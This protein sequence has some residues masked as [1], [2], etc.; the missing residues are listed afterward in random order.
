MTL[1][2]DVFTLAYALRQLGAP[3]AIEGAEAVRLE[4]VC[5]DSRQAREGSLFVALP[6]ERTD[7]HLYVA[8]AFAAGA[9]AALIQR[10][11]PGVP[12]LDLAAAHLPERVEA[13]IA[14]R[15]EN[16]LAA[17]QRLAKAY[18]RDHPHLR[19]IGVTGSVGKTTAK[20]AI[21]AV[22]AQRFVTL[23]NEGNANNEIGLPLTLLTLTPRY[24]RAVLEMAMYALGE[25]A[26]L[27]DLAQPALG[28]VMNVGPTHLERLGSIERIAQAKAELVQALPPEGLAILNG[29]DPRVRAMAALSAAPVVTFG[30]GP[31]ND[32]CALDVQTLGL[33]GI[34]FELAVQTE[35]FP[36]APQEAALRTPL[37]GRHAVMPALA[38]VAVGLAEGLTWEEITR[39][40]EAMGGGP[41][42][43]PKRLS[44]GALLLDDTYNA[45]PA[46]CQAALD[47]L[48]SLAGRRIAVLGDMLEL[49]DY[50][51]EA[52]REV[53]ALCASRVE[54]LLTVG[55]RARWIAESAR[56]AGLPPQDITM[57]ET[58]QEA[59]DWL[60]TFLREGDVVLIKGS[61]GM[62]M[63]EIVYGLEGSG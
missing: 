52:H 14:I 40:L 56:E 45:S 23:K 30:L 41:R 49:G 39:G 43:V 57:V 47:L 26:L 9:K 21:A 63:E 3:R 1:G 5:I 12:T 51:R 38:A 11:V 34:V 7:G 36:Q 54:H 4:Q 19:V 24:E 58:N 13:P 17:L 8:Q 35:R 29:D 48:A 61:R 53:G 59:L 32:L 60:K 16:T 44:S 33:G 46:S 55:H 28:V 15:V 42:L 2:K 20:E 50:E 62:A 18:R 10:E 6:G 31:E 25:I 22:L 27:C 37:L